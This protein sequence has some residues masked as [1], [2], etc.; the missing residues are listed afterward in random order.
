M[1][2]E[3]WQQIARV[4]QSAL[5]HAPAT[6]G[7]FLADACRH[8]SDL[9]REVE[10][11][12][13]EEHASVLVDHAVDVAAAAVMPSAPGLA[14]GAAIGPY[15]V[16]ALIGEG[17][18][19]QVYRAHDTK[20]QRDVALKI[21]PDA[22]VH[23]HD[24][25]ARFTREAQVL[26]SLNHPN[27]GAI[28]GFEDSGPVHALVL[29]L[30]EGPTLADR[31]ARGPIAVDEALSIA[32]QI[33]EAL[34]AAHEH[35]IVHR[36]LKPANIKVRD[37][38]TV[39]VL[40]FGLAKP[41]IAG[42]TNQDPV[43]ARVGAPLTQSPTIMS[44]AV[45]GMGVILG[46]AAYMSPEQ[47][48]GKPADKRS[49]IWAFGCVLYEMLS[50]RRAFDGEDVSDTLAAVLR[51]DPDWNVLP[52]LPAALRRLL[53]TC[54]QKDQRKRNA[55]ATTAAF[56]LENAS[57]LAGPAGG[58]P[59]GTEQPVSRPG[60]RRAIGPLAAAL[61]A[62]T[63]VGGVAWMV[64]RGP[65]PVV[66][67]VISTAGAPL[68]TD[69]LGRTIVI[70]PDGSRIVY[71][72]S[73][74]LFVRSLDSLNAQAV[75][76]ADRPRDLFMSP[77]GQFVGYFD[78]RI[79]G[80]K[81]VAIAG[82]PPLT[83]VA[84]TENAMRG[85][86]WGPDGTIIYGDSALGNGL[87]SV[88]STGGTP[89]LLT[90]PD[91]ARGE[92]DHI[93]P[94]FLPGGNA[95]LFT[96]QRFEGRESTQIAVLDLRTGTQKVLVQ[97]GID[98]RYVPS[99]HLVYTVPV[100]GSVQAV[101]FDLHRLEVADV[102]V[103][104]LDGVMTIGEAQTAIAENGTLAYVPGV[105]SEV[106][107]RTLVWV[108]RMGKEELI[109]GLDL[110]SY[111]RVRLSPDGTR[112]AVEGRGTGTDASD[113]SVWD[114]KRQHSLRLTFE[115]T[116]DAYPAWA[117]NDRIIFAASGATGTTLYSKAADGTGV[118]E[119][120]TTSQAFRAPQGITSSGSAL[121]LREGR[122]G[123]GVDL[124]L[125]PLRPPGPARP[126]VSTPAEEVG[127]EISPDGHW[128]AYQASTPGA[129]EVI[130]RP[131]PAV[132]GGYW[133]VSNGGGRMPMW[134]RDGRELFYV[135]PDDTLMA[136]RVDAGKSFQ[137]STPTQVLAGR[138][139]YPG[140]PNSRTFDISPDGQRFL[141]IKIVNR[142]DKPRDIVVV[143]NWFTELKRLVPVP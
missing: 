98:G 53:Q 93:L 44:P 67:T 43:Y 70:T 84:R 60:W 135:G 75:R 57:A 11:L 94:E 41:A 111:Q 101:P 92:S 80:L 118:A 52:E 122:N 127:A 71:T 27:I 104:V 4:Y 129:P 105:A 142:D 63:A 50:G 40:D 128:L 86:T 117:S 115:P 110:R 58:A 12:L 139:Y 8:D 136:V 102:P 124:V 87:F 22:F 28:H 9:R 120:L 72:G 113:I 34:E 83:I 33:A 143:Q 108:D 18:M 17:G 61:V 39:K 46:T 56:V 88:P 48:K 42:S 126:L 74:G 2:P 109:P 3:R 19:G 1:T 68:D 99:G 106:G 77:D 5:E 20:L 23:D 54:L 35:G 97:G 51:G 30:V 112:A 90:K 14:P 13:A 15:R 45:T 16:M 140:G 36:D 96:I 29:E 132:D 100:V 79:G 131:F 133:Q 26:A 10:S 24:R 21:L 141:M 121:I 59:I 6:R 91:R 85:A 49:D 134:S 125:L 76:T 78:S 73:D 130:V 107:Y 137:F 69:L 55:D 89:R 138:Y 114:F 81:K 64:Q 103:P 116:D 119:P 82:G 95:V 123:P 7:A 38:G 66:R 32:K 37:D 25:V 65:S 47:A 31:I 62:A